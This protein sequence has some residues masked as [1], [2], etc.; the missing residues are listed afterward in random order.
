LLWV[1]I[2]QFRKGE[3]KEAIAE[4]LLEAAAKEGG[5]GRVVLLGI[6]QEKASAWPRIA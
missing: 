5:Q 2:R 4:P 6:A 3:K 1:P